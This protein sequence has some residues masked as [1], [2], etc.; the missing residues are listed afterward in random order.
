MNRWISSQEKKS[1]L[2]WFIDNHRLK[3]TEAKRLIELMIKHVHILDNV[4]FTDDVKVD[5]KLIVISS[6]NSDEVGFKYYKN[7]RVYE[8]VA[9]AYGDLMANPNDTYY[10]LLHFYGKTNHQKYLQLV[11]K[12]LIDNIRR[13]EY[14]QRVTK[15]ADEIL[16]QSLSENEKEILKARIDKALDD[17]DEALFKKLVEELMRYEE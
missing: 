7:K 6:T 2:K 17:K 9:V 8:D 11:E 15:E 13:Y 1:F 14:Y 4:H 3:R 5:Q 16:S 12:K 10:I